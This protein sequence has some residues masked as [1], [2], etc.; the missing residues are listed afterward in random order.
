[1]NMWS[2]EQAE[3]KEPLA[4]LD[5]L[6]G[7]EREC[8]ADAAF[9]LTADHGMNYKRRCWDLMRACL[10][11]GVDLRFALSAE[12]TAMSNTT[13]RSAEQ[14]GFGSDQRLTERKRS[15]HFMVWKES[16]RC[17]PG[18]RSRRSQRCWARH[19]K[20]ERFFAA[21]IVLEAPNRLLHN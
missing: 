4:R 9:L 14:G 19:Y 16:N 13:V 5:A 20:Y 1:M 12:K 21:S 3:S 2:P 7:E 8:A 6:I 18:R 11:R 10:R 15:P 17:S